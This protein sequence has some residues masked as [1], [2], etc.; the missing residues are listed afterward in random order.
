[1]SLPAS[2]LLAA[3]CYALLTFFLL[4]SL[5]VA[6]K[7]EKRPQ[8]IL[9][10][11]ILAGFEVLSR[12]ALIASLT[13]LA[14]IVGIYGFT[15]VSPPT[16]SSTQRFLAAADVLSH[17][18]STFKN[19]WTQLLFTLAFAISAFVFYRMSKNRLE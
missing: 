18:L 19:I 14:M 6:W 9:R 5:R 7:S 1:M 17:A 3:S 10:A 15:L 4:P 2:L 16:V 8:K 11:G 13:I 12:F